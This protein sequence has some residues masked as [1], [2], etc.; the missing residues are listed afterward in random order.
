MSN[1]KNG[2]YVTKNAPEQA[3]MQEP[4]Q[5]QAQAQN[6]QFADWEKVDSSELW[7]QIDKKE[8]SYQTEYRK[9][10]DIQQILS[11][12]KRRNSRGEEIEDSPLMQAV[13]R[14]M[15]AV[16]SR[17]EE[18][19]PEDKEAFRQSLF[20]TA[21]L[22][23]KLI[24]SCQDYIDGHSPWSSVGKRPHALRAGTMEFKNSHYV[25]VKTGLLTD[26][27]IMV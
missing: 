18:E 2:L 19:I 9:H 17:L 16:S 7:E 11:D 15:N 12:E 6:N 4:V 22:Y 14:D 5:D 23:D 10:K 21:A 27:I 1:G 25:N 8:S 24:K 3:P 26:G 20:S 13:K